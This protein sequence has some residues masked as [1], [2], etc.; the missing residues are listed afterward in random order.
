M[1]EYR[2]RVADA[3]LRARMAAVGAVLIEGPKACGK[4]S[5]ACQL[6]AT[7]IQL[8]ED[9]SARE[10]VCA[11][12]ELLFSGPT[13]I[14]FDEWQVEPQ[15]WNRVRRQVDDRQQRGLYILTGS[16]TPRDDAARHSGAGRFAALR[17]RPMTLFESGH[18][19]GEVSLAAL[20]EGRAQ[21]S[22]GGPVDVPA[23]AE[24]IVIGGWPALLSASVT[25]AQRWVRDYLRNMVEVDVPG[26]GHRRAP[27]N[28]NR[29]MRSLAR[30]VGQAAKLS[31]LRKDVA[32]DA[33]TATFETLSGY[34]QALERLMLTENSE[35]WATH[36]RS[37]TRLR[38]APVRYFV[39]PSLGAAALGIGTRQLL[40]DL[41]AAG[42][43]FEALAVRDL[44]VY[45]QPI[46]GQVFSWR[47][48][49]GHEIDAVVS[50]LDGRWGAFEVKLNPADVDAA[51]ASLLRFVRK[52]DTRRVGDPAALGVI[53][54]TG[55][56]F[57]RTDGVHVIPI[58]TLGP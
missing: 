57:R 47:D 15:L 25:E 10:A 35:A 3:E 48:A 8:D 54:S 41:N 24:R 56:A 31:E 28:L 9:A 12:P 26:L 14:L 50:T 27:G 17:M 44:R 30:S 39:D 33:G 37:R 53:T 5:T 40:N 36:M 19:S 49:N 18:S 55:M 52:V 7:I 43:H 51:A 1:F 13:P 6:A 22:A 29:L 21:K 11:A 42:F 38:S 4:T 23:L 20:F 16:A 45:C 32:G 34:L 46:D 2:S 58:G